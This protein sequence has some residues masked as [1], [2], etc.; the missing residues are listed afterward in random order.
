MIMVL[1]KI[2]SYRSRTYR[3]SVDGKLCE[4]KKYLIVDINNGSRAG[5]GFHIAPEAKADDGLLDVILID[6][7]HSF[8]RLRW[9]PVIEKG[10]HLSRSF[11]HYSRAKKVSIES[12]EIIQSHLDGEYYTGKRLEIEILPGKLLFRY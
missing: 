1:K 12:D 9:L 4:S 8:R 6:A 2:F 3:I 7:M 5:G 10:R 11:I